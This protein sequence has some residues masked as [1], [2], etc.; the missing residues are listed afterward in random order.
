MDNNK[1]TILVAIDH[2]RQSIDAAAY[3][4]AI[5]HPLE[6]VVTLF[7]VESDLFDIFFDYDDTP[8]AV[9]QELSHFSDWMDIQKRAI[10]DNLEEAEQLFLKM[11]FPKENIRIVKRPLTK[12]ITRD[13]LDESQKDY[14]LLVTGKSGAHRTNPEQTGTVTTKLLSRTFHIPLVIVAGTPDT[15]KV[16][17]GYDGSAG[18][19]KA[20]ST[21]ARLLRQNLSEVQLCH[22][23]RSFNLA[24]AQNTQ[25]YTSFYNS[26]LPEL[27]EALIKIRR[28]KMEPLLT[29]ACDVFVGR[30]FLPSGVRWSLINRMASRSQALLDMAEKQECGTLILGRRG[31]SAVEEFFMG[32]VGK[33]VVQLAESIAVWII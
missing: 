1:N 28:D 13:I 29:K 20:V 25:E 31:N 18:A 7:H 3:I 12:G 26:Y 2:S 27:E 8:P 17:L 15:Y 11:D 16:L 5:L 4:S 23:I 30:G 9:L 14:D 19:D 32:R 6:N 24:M 21:A 10:D 22:V 33:K